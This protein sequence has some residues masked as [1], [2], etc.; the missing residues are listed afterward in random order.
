MIH[1][2][3][4]VCP[5]C[6]LRSSVPDDVANRYCACCGSPPF[7][8]KDCRHRTPHRCPVCDERLMRVTDP[9]AADRLVCTYPSCGRVWFAD[10][11]GR[12]VVV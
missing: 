7:L 3:V 1:P 11:R 12:P 10:A 5:F 4:F 9:R 2:E 6:G 8:P